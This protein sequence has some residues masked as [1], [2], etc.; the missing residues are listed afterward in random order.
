M[1]TPKMPMKRSSTAF[2]SEFLKKDSVAMTDCVQKFR[3]RLSLSILGKKE[4]QQ[5]SK[6]QVSSSSGITDSKLYRLTLSESEKLTLL[7]QRSSST[8][9]REKQSV[10]KAC[11]NAGSFQNLHLFIHRLGSVSISVA[12]VQ[13]VYPFQLLQFRECIH[14]S[15]CNLGSVFISVAVVLACNSFYASV[16]D[17]VIRSCQY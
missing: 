9:E 7:S 15:Y 4:W 11:S 8:S 1:M 5:S 12:V 6:L 2:G 10:D 13:G 14:F 3:Q 17:E 16:S